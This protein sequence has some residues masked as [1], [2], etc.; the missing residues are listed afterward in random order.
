MYDV[1]QLHQYQQKKE[2]PLRTS[3]HWTQ[4]RARHMAFENQVMAGLN[5]L[6]ESKP[7]LSDNWISNDN[8]DLNK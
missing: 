3:N 7:Y 4:N 1:Q 5:H 8:T 6:M 2:Q